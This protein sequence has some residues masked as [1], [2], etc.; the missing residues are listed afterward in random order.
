MMIAEIA[1]TNIRLTVIEILITPPSINGFQMSVI[2]TA[3]R[4]ANTGYQMA[5]TNFSVG[6]SK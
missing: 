1:E 4:I 3:T 6:P 2:K 5:S